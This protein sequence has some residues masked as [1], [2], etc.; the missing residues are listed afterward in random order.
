MPQD[1]NTTA[2]SQFDLG[3]ADVLNERV[4]KLLV[5]SLLVA[6]GGCGA[7]DRVDRQNPWGETLAPTSPPVSAYA[8]TNAPQFQPFDP[9]AA[10]ARPTPPAGFSPGQ[11]ASTSQPPANTDAQRPPNGFTQPPP[12]VGAQP[13][14]PYVNPP[15]QA[16]GVAPG[17]APGNTQGAS[18]GGAAAPF[19]SGVNNLQYAP[20]TVQPGSPYENRVEST[21]AAATE[22]NLEEFEP[23]K[24]VAQVGSQYILAGDVLGGVNQMLAPHKEKMTEQQYAQQKQQLV[25]RMVT[26]LID[27][28]LLY[29]LFLEAVPADRREEALGNIRAQAYGQ[30]DEAELPKAMKQAKVSTPAELD[31]Y[32]RRF[33]S[34]LTKQKEQYMELQLGRTAIR[35]NIDFNPEVTHQQMLDYYREHAADFDFEAKARW[36]K[37]TIRHDKFQDRAQARYA[38]GVLGDQVRLG[39]A[40]LAAVAK[41]GSQGFD[42]DEGGYHDWTTR[43]SLRSEKL[44]AAIF[45]LPPGLL[46]DIIED[47]IGFHIVRVI[48]RQ[49]AGR[50]S[51]VE[52]QVKIKEELLKQHRQEQIKTFLKKLREN[53]DVW[54]IFDESEATETTAAPDN[55][56]SPG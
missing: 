41:R 53:A 52:A 14:A 51:F 4:R 56:S 55:T 13:P 9:N 21:P 48:E 31:A 7:R 3:M 15:G 49:E 10:H 12:Y 20:Q 30:Y 40:P 46:S 2:G 17:N 25:R 16:P 6:A 19:A 35:Q 47:D 18:P 28:K 29:N 8:A 42:A 34:S 54:T 26:Q 11:A 23:A 5:A 36:E 44:D 1:A 32:L 24:I 27:T 22:A 38:I 33:G 43:G 50:T 45:T 37:L 39:G